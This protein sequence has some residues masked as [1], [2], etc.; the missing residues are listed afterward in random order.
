MARH[1]ACLLRVF[2]VYKQV[3]DEG[4]VEIQKQDFSIVG[5]HEPVIAMR[6][7]PFFFQNQSN[8]CSY[9]NKMFPVGRHQGERRF[10]SPD[11]HHIKSFSSHCGGLRNERHTSM[12]LCHQQVFRTRPIGIDTQGRGNW[13]V[14]EGGTGV[15][16][17]S[18]TR[19]SDEGHVV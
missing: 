17:G 15:W 4:A 16:W 7:Y 9:R 3:A 14:G 13:R 8:H 1:P 5:K 18:S 19:R 10:V 11:L 2:Q 6:Q 12:I